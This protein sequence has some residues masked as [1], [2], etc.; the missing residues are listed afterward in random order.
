M[1]NKLLYILL[2]FNIIGCNSLEK[3]V[4]SETV[5]IEDFTKVFTYK[6]NGEKVTGKVLFYEIDPNSSKKFKQAERTV[7]DGKRVGIGFDYFPN[8]KISA[9]Y[10]YDSAGFI[11]GIVKEYYDNGNLYAET[12]YKKNFEDGIR[13]EYSSG[14]GIQIKEIVFKSGKK[15]QEYDFNDNGEKIIPAIEQ[16]ELVTYK[17]GFYEYVNYNNN[18]ILYQPMVILKWKNKTASPLTENIEIEGVFINNS[19][20]EEMDLASVY[21]QGYS[22]SP[23]QANLSRQCVLQSSVGYTSPAGIY[24]AN[25]SCQILINQQLYKTI[26]IS[27]SFLNTNRIQ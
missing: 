20:N 22:D 19:K 6:K 10:K 21:F 12:E 7:K 4:D 8:G 16:L 14:A 13:K 3:E 27:N 18:E 26:K 1:K 11:T 17:T 23:L 24:R 9:I 5:K 15:L 25:I 2:F